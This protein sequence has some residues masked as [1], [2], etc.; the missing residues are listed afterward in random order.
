VP[1][2]NDASPTGE[3]FPP[4]L[5]LPEPIDVENM[6]RKLNQLMAERERNLSFHVDE[7]SGRTVITVRDATTDE[8]VRQIPADEV[9]VMKRALEQT[10]ALLDA[11]V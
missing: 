4:K 1:A 11:Q 9:L 10:G 7:S 2:G 6:V 3:F 8:I 5:A